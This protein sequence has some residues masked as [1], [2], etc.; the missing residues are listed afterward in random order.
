VASA[1]AFLQ[2]RWGV[3]CTCFL[4]CSRVAA[5][6][7]FLQC[8]KVRPIPHA[9]TLLI[10]SPNDAND[11]EKNFSRISDAACD[12]EKETERGMNEPE[13]DRR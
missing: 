3:L 4:Q 5:A 6:N 12:T 13:K 10:T 2:S 9:K 8:R 1:Q 7:N 11:G